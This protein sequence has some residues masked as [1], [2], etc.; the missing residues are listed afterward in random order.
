VSEY[1]H[2]NIWLHSDG[3]FAIPPDTYAAILFSSVTGGETWELYTCEIGPKAVC[4]FRHLQNLKHLERC[5]SLPT[6]IVAKLADIP[7]YS[8]RERCSD[9]TGQYGWTKR[10][11][12][13]KVTKSLI[14]ECRELFPIAGV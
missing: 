12:W 11:N 3:E 9:D 2:Y 14:A 4:I 7:G 8:D 6:S 13:H 10:I 5:R 1:P